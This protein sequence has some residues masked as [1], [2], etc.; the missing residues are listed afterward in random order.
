MENVLSQAYDLAIQFLF[1]VDDPIPEAIPDVFYDTL[2][3]LKKRES[4]KSTWLAFNQNRFYQML[5][6]RLQEKLTQIC[7]ERHISLVEHFV[8]DSETGYQADPAIIRRI[9]TSLHNQ[10]IEFGENII[11]RG[12]PVLGVIFVKEHTVTVLGI[13]DSVRL[14]D[15]NETGFFGEWEVIFD[16][17]AERSYVATNQNSMCDIMTQYYFIK[18]SDFMAILNEF[19]EFDKF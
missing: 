15:F 16:R 7:L 14:L 12:E 17:L 18:P 1:L 9:V 11:T 10:V 19:E 13:A 8:I 2:A 6:P 5:P 4:E 3:N